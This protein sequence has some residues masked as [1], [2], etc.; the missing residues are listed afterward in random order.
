[1]WTSIS[2]NGDLMVDFS[3]IIPVYNVEKY[4]ADSVESALN[5][6]G[7]SLEVVLVDDA[8]TDKSGALC[9]VFQKRDKRVKVVHNEKNSYVGAARNKGLSLSEGEY[10]YFLD[11]DDVMEDGVLLYVKSIIEGQEE[12]PDV[13]ASF[14][15]CTKKPDGSKKLH[16][17]KNWSLPVRTRINVFSPF[18]GQ[19]FYRRDFLSR[20][21]IPFDEHRM[22]AEDRKW[23]MENIRFAKSVAT[24]DRPFYAYTM[25]REGSLLNLIRADSLEYSLSEMKKLFDGLPDSGYEDGGALKRKI[26]DHYLTIAACCAIVRDKALRKKLI[27]HVKGD[28]Y[29]LKDKAC[30]AHPFIWIRHITGITFL[31]RVCNAVFLKYRT[32]K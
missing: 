6:Q 8:S 31:L 1:M 25:R 4:L 12:K 27:S 18:V 13:V 17:D 5:Q 2:E 23:L 28:V 24:A 29:I 11:S 10:V 19:N 30:L 14:V 16:S 22:L 26:A 20:V 21:N 15:H 3:I 7:V 32:D 9:D